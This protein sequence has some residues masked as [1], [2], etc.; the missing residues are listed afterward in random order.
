MTYLKLT[1]SPLRP[2]LHLGPLGHKQFI[3]SLQLP[4]PL[5]PRAVPSSSSHG[6]SQGPLCSFRQTPEK[7]VKWL[8]GQPS[9][10][11]LCNPHLI[12]RKESRFLNLDV[13]WEWRPISIPMRPSLCKSHLLSQAG[14]RAQSPGPLGCGAHVANSPLKPFSWN[15]ASFLPHSG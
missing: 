15:W 2:L 1:L 13:F 5:S 11:I 10:S 9:S 6:D 14:V 3:L 8:P 7:E 12:P 4:P